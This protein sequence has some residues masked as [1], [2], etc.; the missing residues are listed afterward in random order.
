M[1]LLYCLLW[2][3]TWLSFAKTSEELHYSKVIS[4]IIVNKNTMNP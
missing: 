4:N 3:E 1:S 2:L